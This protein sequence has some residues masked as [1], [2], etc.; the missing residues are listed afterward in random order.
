M[1]DRPAPSWRLL[2]RVG[3]GVLA[4]DTPVG[5]QRRALVALAA[6]IVLISGLA[7]VANLGADLVAVAIIGA[8]ITLHELGHFV[9]AKLSG[10]KVT[11]F[12]VGVGPRLW[13]VRRG[14]TEYG[15]RPL[16]IIGY[17][18][19]LGMNNLE[20]VDPAE[21]SRTYRAQTFPRR[22]IT[23]SAGSAVHFILALIAAWTLFAFFQQGKVVPTVAAFPTFSS[24][25]TPAERAGMQVGDKIV[26]YDGHPTNGS[27]TGL[28]TYI[29]DNIGHTITLV[30]ARHGA[31]VTLRAAPEDASKVVDQGQPISTV[32]LGFLGFDATGRNDSLLA[33]IPPAVG[34]FFHDGI[35]GTFSGIGAIFSPSGLTNLGKQVVSSPGSTTAQQAGNR[36]ASIV[37]VVQ[38]ANQLPG[39]PLKILL[40]MEAN[41][42]IGV[43]N[44]F[45]ILP[46]DGGHIIIAVYERL[47]SR[48]GHRYV[49]DVNKMLPYALA[50]MMVVGFVFLTSFYLDV[51]HPIT[52]R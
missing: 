16:L 29:E 33:S 18:R 38:I 42:F 48:R 14:E 9:C 12:Y 6:G 22:V 13:S 43:L 19:I 36:P 45:P 49:A 21:E 40:F 30:V 23:M 24:G 2:D 25:P 34:K 8:V 17:N 20:V 44:L 35:G 51:A 5:D 39:W 50:V 47:R 4:D 32:H 3:G 11:E 15:I 46:F 28:H 10:M 41:A 26:S 52:L 31:L 1:A 27:W 37:G 7:I